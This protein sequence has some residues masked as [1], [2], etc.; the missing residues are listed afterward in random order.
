MLLFLKLN[1]CVMIVRGDGK[2][3]GQSSLILT[4][5]GQSEFEHMRTLGPLGKD[6]ASVVSQY[7]R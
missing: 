5:L 7:A 6:S 4:V 2:R 1:H 3:L